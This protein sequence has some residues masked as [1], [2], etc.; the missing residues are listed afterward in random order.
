MDWKEF[1][2]IT[3]SK[4]LVAVI[5]LI[6]FPLPTELSFGFG[7]LYR[8]GPITPV[9]PYIILN[10]IQYPESQYTSLII[11]SLFVWIIILGIISY[12]ISS[13]IFWIFKKK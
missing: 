5:I 13:L 8:I 3:R 7:E 1:L 6:F 10:L 9:I 4:I 2:K 11:L 12:I